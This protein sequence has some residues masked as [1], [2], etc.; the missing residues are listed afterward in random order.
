MAWDGQIMTKYGSPCAYF[1]ICTAR[2]YIVTIV[3][4]VFITGHTTIVKITILVQPD[5]TKITSNWYCVHQQ[6]SLSAWHA[7]VP[8]F[9]HAFPQWHWDQAHSCPLEEHIHLAQTALLMIWVIELHYPGGVHLWSLFSLV[10]IKLSNHR[11]IS[12]QTLWY[13]IFYKFLEIETDNNKKM[14]H[15]LW[16]I[17]M[18]LTQ[19]KEYHLILTVNILDKTNCIISIYLMCERLCGT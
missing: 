16:C 6:A 13:M 3:M 17:Y 14:L 4:K 18:I 1:L 12:K 19:K 10:Q 8:A 7:W 2:K 9:P 5:T 15:T 11:Y